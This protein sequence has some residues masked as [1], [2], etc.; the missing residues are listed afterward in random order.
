M[1]FLLMHRDI[2]T[3]RFLYHNGEVENMQI[4]NTDHL[5]LP[6]KRILHYEY[7]ENS[8]RTLVNE[9]GRY[10]LEEWIDDRSIPMNRLNLK[11]YSYKVSDMIKMHAVSFTDN[12]WIKNADTE[13]NLHWESVNLFS[14][15]KVDTFD[16]IEMNRENGGK[17]SKI[18]NTL[19][20]TLEKYWFASDQRLMLAKKTPI[21]FDMLTIR[22]V[23][24]SNIYR[25]QGYD[26]YCGYH[27][28]INRHSQIVGC[29]CKAFTSAERE[30]ITAYD[31]LAEYGYQQKDDLYEY[32]KKFAEIYGCKREKT[33]RMLDIMTVVDYLITNRDRHQNN[34]GFI[35][36]P[37][38]LK[39]IDTAPI[40]DNGSSIELEGQFPL[41][42]QNT[43]VHN[44]CNTEKECFDQVENKNCIDI[45]KLPTVEWVRDEWKKS[46]NSLSDQ[47]YAG[48]YEQKVVYWKLMRG[49][50]V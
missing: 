32:V 20:G 49:A 21:V 30:L 27:Y 6:L 41:G 9:E 11:L 17:Y 37:V 36:N 3:C 14:N 26:N 50:T 44:L 13:Q 47:K 24:A 38:T 46:E 2:E 43:S 35:R 39:I 31:L 25:M 15:A 19:G 1:N 29:M 45:S 23:I 8:D 34:I 4:L 48:L 40:F 42:V 33:T 7:F 16:A 28:I 12:Y 18:N 5:P 22:E 10:L